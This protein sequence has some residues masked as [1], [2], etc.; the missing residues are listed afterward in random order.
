M[1]A[2]SLTRFTHDMV[3]RVYRHTLG[4]LC[5]GTGEVQKTCSAEPRSS[6]ARSLACSA[7]VNLQ[8]SES[9][10]LV[11]LDRYGACNGF[12]HPCLWF[13]TGLR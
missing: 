4:C 3:A 8:S 12:R 7:Y 9:V 5:S 6:D 2:V 11:S 1:Q 13:G 10:P